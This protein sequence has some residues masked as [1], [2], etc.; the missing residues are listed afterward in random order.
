VNAC[1]VLAARNSTWSSDQLDALLSPT[2]FTAAL[3][4]IFGGY[5]LS[6]NLLGQLTGVL[7][8][9]GSGVSTSESDVRGS[10]PESDPI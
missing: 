6:I 10:A 4:P 5:A 9:Y 8:E 7:L 1:V 2:S 3:L